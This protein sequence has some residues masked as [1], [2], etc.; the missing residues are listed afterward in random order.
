[1]KR[2]LI[3]TAHD[4]GYCHSINEGVMYA[5][6]HKNNIITELSL[7]ANTP[8]SDEAVKL[9]RKLN[10]SVS[11]N[12]NFTSHTPLSKNV[13]SMIGEDGNFLPVDVSK[14]DFSS[15]DKY[16]EKDIKRELDAQ[17]DW[18]VKNMGRKPSAILSKKNEYGDPKI[19]IPVVDKA[20]MEGVA[21]RV[22]QW[23]WSDNYGA[24]SYVIQEGVKSTQNLFLGLKPWKGKYGFDLEEDIDRLIESV[25]N[26]E[27][28]SELLVFPGFV[29]K[30][31]MD[32]SS[33][34]WERGQFLAILDNNTVIGKIKDNFELISFRDL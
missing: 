22:P 9:S 12:T 25:Y 1:M 3:V 23:M 15:I 27:G 20:K 29:D 10:V 5:F 31:L 7:L 8:G 2:K 24:E 4:F 18:F 11:L 13:K 32:E 17:W 34:N 30:E 28:V 26:R 33:L 6:S 14:W 19:L 21:I 16:D